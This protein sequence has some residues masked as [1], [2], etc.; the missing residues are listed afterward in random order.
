MFQIFVCDIVICMK[1][2]IKLYNI[3]KYMQMLS[4]SV[5]TH[6]MYMFIYVFYIDC[7]Q[8]LV[9]ETL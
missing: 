6:K 8:I 9:K 5:K 4:L 2:F 7:Y 1:I 3:L